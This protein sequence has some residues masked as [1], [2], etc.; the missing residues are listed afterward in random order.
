M[1]WRLEI[2]TE[3]EGS[4]GSSMLLGMRGQKENKEKFFFL[5]LS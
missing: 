2:V 5:P 3:N 1:F 4:T